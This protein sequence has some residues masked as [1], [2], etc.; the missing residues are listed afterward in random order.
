[1]MKKGR[2]EKTIRQKREI[3]ERS[4]CSEKGKLKWRNA[5]TTTTL[6]P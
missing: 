4:K 3:K 5:S 6:A 1:M 2:K